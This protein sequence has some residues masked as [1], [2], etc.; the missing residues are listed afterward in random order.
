MTSSPKFSVMQDNLEHITVVDPRKAAE[1]QAYHAKVAQT[2]EV[3]IKRRIQ[4]DVRPDSTRD[5]PELQVQ[6]AGIP[7]DTDLEWVGEE[8]IV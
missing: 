4:A 2:Q 5:S 8:G 6:K 1:Q 3:E 7:E